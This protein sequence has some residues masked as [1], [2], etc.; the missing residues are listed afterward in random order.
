MQEAVESGSTA[1][2]PASYEVALT[3]AQTDYLRGEATPKSQAVTAFAYG[4][5]VPVMLGSLVWGLTKLVSRV[6]IIGWLLGI[7][8][9][10]ATIVLAC[11]GILV[12]PITF[13]ATFAYGLIVRRT[14]LRR[15]VDGG[16]A[17]QVTGTFPVNLWGDRG[18]RIKLPEKG[19]DL[20]SEQMNKI[21]PTLDA[22]RQ[23][24]GTVVHSPNAYELLGIERDGAVVVTRD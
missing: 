9:L 6:P 12:L 4:L 2:A 1:L 10:L 7:Y 13:L 20:N 17:V 16:R 19:V 18:G 8:G 3:P 22:S 5:M 14:K 23:F 21:R 24:S 15:D 11:A